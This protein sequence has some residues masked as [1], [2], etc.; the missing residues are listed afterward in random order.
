MRSLCNGKAQ[1]PSVI[2]KGLRERMGVTT[3]RGFYLCF[4]LP[5][6]FELLCDR[7]ELQP[8]NRNNAASDC[9]HYDYYLYDI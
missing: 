7:C 8:A 1:R 9:C 6:E 2:E 4:Y 3:V 5:A